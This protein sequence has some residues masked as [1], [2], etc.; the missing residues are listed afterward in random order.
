MTAQ[1]KF[2][3]LAAR[4]REATANRAQESAAIRASMDRRHATKLAT[5]D[6]TGDACPD[7]G[8]ACASWKSSELGT[9]LSCPD[10][11]DFT[12]NGNG[13]WHRRGHS[14]GVANREV[15]AFAAP[16]LPLLPGR[17]VLTVERV[18]DGERLQLD[19]TDDLTAAELRRFIGSVAQWLESRGEWL[20]CAEVHE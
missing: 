12:R 14:A 20:R 19:A 9:M 7:C 15:L 5:R 16:L 10:C 2:Q 11:G 6:V 13:G 17:T 4:G 1:A 18:S 3:L 8:G